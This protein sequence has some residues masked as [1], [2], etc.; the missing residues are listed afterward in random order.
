MN[1]KNGTWAIWKIPK[2]LQTKDEIE[3]ITMFDNPNENLLNELKP[4]IILCGLNLSNQVV[5]Q[6]TNFHSKGHDYKI[7][8]AV[9]DTKFWG[10]YMTDI[11]KNKIEIKSEKVM[12]YLKNNPEVEKE[13]IINFIKELQNIKSENPIIVAFGEK[14][15]KILNRNINLIQKFFSTCRIYQV[16]H[17]SYRFNKQ[18]ILDYRNEFLNIEEDLKKINY[19]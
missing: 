2:N 16:T 12:A 1:S 3:D 5:K 4:N 15:Y 13:N 18:Q 6:Y 19:F 9:I 8:Q 10:A 7:R 11:I 14:V 17:Y